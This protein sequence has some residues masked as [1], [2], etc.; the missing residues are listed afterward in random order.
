MPIS[1]LLILDN[2]INIHASYELT[3]TN[4]VTRSTG[5]LTFHITAICHE[6][7]CLTH[8]TCIFCYS[9]TIVYKYTQHY[10]THQSKITTKLNL[11]YHENYINNSLETLIWQK[12]K[13]PLVGVEPDASHLLDECPRLL[14]HRGFPDLP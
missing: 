5:I 12:R 2:Y 9:S 8:C 10:C 7:L 3:A 11:I 14:N 6:H 4:S 1:S 13:F